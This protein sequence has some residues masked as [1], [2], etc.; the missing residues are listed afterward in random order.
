MVKC[1]NCETNFRGSEE[2]NFRCPNC[3]LE[4]EYKCPD[5]GNQIKKKK[6]IECKK[7]GFFICQ[8]CGSCHCNSLQMGW[9]SNIYY[10]IDKK[11]ESI[12]HIGYRFS[13]T[14]TKKSYVRLHDEIE[15]G[16][17]S[18]KDILEQI[19]QI[20]RT[21]NRI[22]EDILLCP[23][24]IAK[25]NIFEEGKNKNNTI[26]GIMKNVNFEKQNLAGTH[27]AEL[28]EQIIKQLN[29]YK[30]IDPLMEFGLKKLKTDM[31]DSN[32]TELDITS[33]ATRTHTETCFC[34]GI[35]SKVKQGG[36]GKESI[37]TFGDNTICKYW[38]IKDGVAQCTCPIDL[39]K[40]YKLVKNNYIPAEESDQ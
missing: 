24:L 2:N 17:K 18:I 8:T 19:I 6:S 3:G 23:R 13:K 29:V 9:Y 1:V 20:A 32:R 31:K 10:E 11:D 22:P 40:K 34:K 14:K 35:L 4:P 39:F 37:Y 12:A 25:S 36:V 21:G 28:I 30:Q 5:C 16:D 26:N 7:C 27:Y 15:V 33:Q 38:D